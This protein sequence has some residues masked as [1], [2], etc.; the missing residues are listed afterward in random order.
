M[1]TRAM[2][3]KIAENRISVKAALKVDVKF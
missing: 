1:R 3:E 2:E